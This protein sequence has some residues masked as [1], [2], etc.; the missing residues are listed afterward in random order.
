[1]R[2]T[3]RNL[4]LV[5]LVLGLLQVHPP[6]CAL[7][8]PSGIALGWGAAVIKPG[9]TFTNIAAGFDHRVAIRSDGTVFDWGDVPGAPASASNIINVA[10]GGCTLSGAPYSENHTVALKADGTVMAW[11]GNH[12]GQSTVPPNLTNIVAVSAGGLHSLALRADGTVV[13]WGNNSYGQTNVPT[14]YTNWTFVPL[15]NVTAI[16]AGSTHSLARKQDGTLVCW[17]ESTYGTGL[18]NVAAVAAGDRYSVLLM[19]DGRVRAGVLGGFLW[20]PVSNCVA[21]A[22]GGDFA[23]PNHGLALRKDGTVYAWGGNSYGQA[24]VPPGLS[25]V[26]AIAAERYSSFA[27]RAD[28]TIVSWGLAGSGV[29]NWGFVENGEPVSSLVALAAG[30]AGYPLGLKSDGSVTD[31]AGGKSLPGGLTNI[32]ALAVGGA[33]RLALRKDGT[34]LAWGSNPYGQASVGGWNNIIAIAAGPYHSL[35]LKSNGTVLATGLDPY[36]QPP[37]GL[38]NV[39]S[40]SSQGWTP[41]PSQ[42]GAAPRGSSLALKTDGTVVGWGDR[43]APAGLAGV[44][45]VAAGAT[46]GL[47][48]QGDSTVLGWGG[49]RYGQAT[50]VPSTAPDYSATGQVMVAGQVLSN[51]I[52]IAAGANHSLALKNDGTVVAWGDNYYGQ[53]SV[54]AEVSNVVAI[55]A[56]GNQ[57]L[58]IKSDLKVDSITLESQGAVIRFHTFAGQT[59][60]VEY[61]PDLSPT[62]WGPVASGSV[63]GD[64]HEAAVTDIAPRVAGSRFYRIRSP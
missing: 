58:A 10:A 21:I 40:L 63:S 18:T 41:A 49:N 45:A 64:G 35:G 26:V 55:A 20:I 24:T 62:N 31:L 17:G 8:Q 53:T 7:T 9:I 4:S 54:P 37:I 12:F 32:A 59:Y 27:L 56:G 5:S 11:G 48:L 25:N 3:L 60:L 44:L 28:G 23:E 47:A 33:H 39:V 1:M 16:S 13:A 61:S 22:V 50:G 38:S 52:A 15:S 42:G 36:T 46:H 29:L 19:G 14:T 51:V 6:L 34:V 57:S 30:A 43:V 2:S